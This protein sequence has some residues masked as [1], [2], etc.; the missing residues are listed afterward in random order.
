ME[1]YILDGENFITKEDAYEYIKSVFDFPDYF[2]N[3]LD[4]L[5]DSLR[6]LGEVQII[7]INAESIRENLEEYGYDILDVFEDLNKFD[8][9]EVEIYD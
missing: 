8:D 4:A 1:R 6:D 2:G 3:N 5:W 7:I 9:V